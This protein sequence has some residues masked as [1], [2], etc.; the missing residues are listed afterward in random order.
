MKRVYIMTFDIFKT[1]IGSLF[2]FLNQSQSI[3]NWLSPAIPGTVFI[4]TT[5]PLQDLRNVLATHMG[6]LP[7][8]LA[9]VSVHS[10][11]GSATQEVWTFIANPPDVPP[12]EP[13]RGLLPTFPPPY[14]K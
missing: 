14:I 6:V 5:L 1:N 4:S 7:F 10:I 12:A 2:Y 11:D 9:E 3:R 8:F 13:Q